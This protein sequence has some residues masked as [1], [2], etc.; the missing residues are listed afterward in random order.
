M[1]GEGRDLTS[2]AFGKWSRVGRV[3]VLATTSANDSATAA[4]TTQPVKGAVSAAPVGRLRNPV[5]EPD[6]GNPHVRFDERG[7]ETE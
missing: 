6:A 4:R 2:G 1:P 3:S 5:G 7:V